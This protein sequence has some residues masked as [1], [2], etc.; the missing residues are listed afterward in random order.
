M[1]E[2]KRPPRGKRESGSTDA[3][4]GVCCQITGL[5]EKTILSSTNSPSEMA[6]V[7]T[8]PQKKKTQ[9]IVGGEQAG[10]LSERSEEISCEMEI[11]ECMTFPIVLRFIC[12]ANI[13][14]LEMETE[15]TTMNE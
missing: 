7:L 2:S 3:L 9:R 5:N 15:T 10:N 4:A 11:L 1:L 14:D 12:P 8:P 13:H 6:A